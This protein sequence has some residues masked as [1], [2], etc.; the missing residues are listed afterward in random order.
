[1]EGYKFGSQQGSIPKRHELLYRLGTAVEALLLQ[2]HASRCKPRLGSI[3]M[4][5]STSM[6]LCIQG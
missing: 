2:M 1:M 5:R 3:A 4:Q 6:L